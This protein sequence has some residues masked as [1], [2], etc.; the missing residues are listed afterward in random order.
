[1]S[2]LRFY[3]AL[4]GVAAITAAIVSAFFILRDRPPADDSAGETD[5]YGPETIVLAPAESRS[6]LGWRR[7]DFEGVVA[8]FRRTCARIASLA[9]DTPVNALEALGEDWEGQSI[10]G[11]A[12]EWRGACEAAETYANT[13]FTNELSSSSAARAMIDTNFRAFHVFAAA[14]PAAPDNGAPAKIEQ[15][16]LFT[17]YF[18]PSYEASTFSSGRF[19]AP[20]YKRP[21]DLVMAELGAFRTALAGERIAGYVEDGRLKPYPDHAAINAGALD[22]KAEVLAWLD[23]NDLLFLQIQGSGRIQLQGGVELR[24]GYDGANGHP[25]T[26]IGRILIERG[27]L[28]RGNVSMQTIRQWLDNASP[29]EAQALREANESYVFFRELEDLEEPALGPLG[30]A[31]VQLTPSRSLAVDRRFIPLGAPVWIS[32]DAVEGRTPEIRRMFIA[33]DTGG[34]IRGPVR[35]D[36]FLGAGPLAADAAGRLAADGEMVVFLPNPVAARL[37]AAGRINAR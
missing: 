30:S 3:L 25:Y 23:P 1:M 36:I 12:L 18:E 34:A 28:T 22:G 4:A 21:S 8:T 32:V 7:D 11:T 35:G 29:E 26:P 31:G 17:A 15:R 9:D 33:Q 14:E 20:L 2:R 16:G 37:E 6:L 13:R 5:L 10:G 19:T 27:E 24:V